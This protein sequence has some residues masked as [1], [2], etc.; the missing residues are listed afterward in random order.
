[1]L[2]LIQ[3]QVLLG[4][5]DKHIQPKSEY[6]LECLHKFGIKS[7]EQAAIT[8]NRLIKDGYVRENTQGLIRL[9]RL[10]NLAEEKAAIGRIYVMM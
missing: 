8:I 3:L 7:K 5:K 2:G 1:M 10:P 6:V 9:E 4:L